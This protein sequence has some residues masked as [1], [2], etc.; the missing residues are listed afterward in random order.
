MRRLL[1][2]L[3]S[4]LI[5]TAVFVAP[6]LRAEVIISEI[7]YNPQ[8]TDLDTAASPDIY[9][10]WAEIY[11]TGSTAVN[12]GGW[13]FGDAADSQW[14]TAFPANTMLQ[15]SQALVITG[16]ASQFDIGWGTG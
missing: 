6:Q 12:I 7:M 5:G 2:R 10:E 16:N 11:N 4:F 8:G 1:L 14:A 3:S 13:Q 15:P 9:R